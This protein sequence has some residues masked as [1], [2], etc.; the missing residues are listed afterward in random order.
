MNDLIF[1]IIV[2]VIVFWAMVK[3]HPIVR[4]MWKK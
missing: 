3:L 2:W 1:Q 4:K